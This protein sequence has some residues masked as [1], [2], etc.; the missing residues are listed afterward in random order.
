MLLF[1]NPF[2]PNGKWNITA[3][4]SYMQS[5][6]KQLYQVNLVIHCLGKYS[7][8]STIPK[9]PPNKGPEVYGGK[10][11][12]SDIANECAM[13]NGVYFVNHAKECSCLGKVDR[14][15]LQKAFT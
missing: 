6:E 13:A 12:G 3:D 1:S 7:D 10:K 9:F 4:N 5:P 8:I 14:T 11:S 2:S 15:H